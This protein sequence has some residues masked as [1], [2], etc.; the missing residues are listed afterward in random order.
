MVTSGG[1]SAEK[2]KCGAP[3]KLVDVEQGKKVQDNLTKREYDF[4]PRHQ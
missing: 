2:N 4:L 1:G 3:K